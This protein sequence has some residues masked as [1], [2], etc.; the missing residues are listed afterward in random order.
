MLADNRLFA[1]L[2]TVAAV[3]LLMLLSPILTPFVASALLAYLFD[4]LVDRLEKLKLSRSLA[5]LLVFIL[6]ILLIIGF[7][8]LALP[9]VKA[10]VEVL[11]EQVPVYI[12]WVESRLLPYLTGLLG[13]D[14][15]D[16]RVGLAEFLKQ[17]WSSASQYAGS[18]LKMVTAPGGWIVSSAVNLLLIPVVTFYLLR[19]WDELIS[20]LGSLVPMDRKTKVFR[21]AKESDEVLGAFLRGQVSVMLALATI[22]STGLAIIGLDNA[23]AIGVIAG[24]VSFVPYLGLVVGIVL[25]GLAAIVQTQSV[26][27]VL[28]VVLVFVVGQLVEGM[29]LTPKLVGDKIGL[30]PVLVIFAVMAGGQLFGFFGILLALPIASVL[31]VVVRFAYEHYQAPKEI[32]DNP[33]A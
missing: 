13:L 23:L 28:L 8:A 5:V 18:A 3:W 14:D 31:S 15:F 26:L 7:V 33:H 2:G 10:Q 9:L 22:Y 11:V 30:H 32:L 21:L 17:N 20:H 25:A 6:M 16:P 12:A 1:L 29:F 27:I 24:L 19:D 4:P